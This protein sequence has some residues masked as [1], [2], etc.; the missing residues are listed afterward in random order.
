[1]RPKLSQ[2]KQ[3]SV[4]GVERELVCVQECRYCFWLYPGGREEENSLRFQPVEAYRI[5]QYGQAVGVEFGR[6]RDKKVCLRFRYYS[7]GSTDWMILHT[8][9]NTYYIPSYFGKVKNFES[10]EDAVEYF[11]RNEDLLRDK[12]EYY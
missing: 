5:D 9:E 11:N 7:N 10:V 3:L 2:L 1:M 8:K 4:D 12:G 6:W